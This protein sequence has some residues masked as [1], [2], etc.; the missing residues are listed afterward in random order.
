ML[1]ENTSEILCPD[2]REGTV[3]RMNILIFNLRELQLRI[4][5]GRHLTTRIQ[6]V[7]SLSSIVVERVTHASQPLPL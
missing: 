7:V 6:A 4:S 2:Q 3:N 5:S 1:T